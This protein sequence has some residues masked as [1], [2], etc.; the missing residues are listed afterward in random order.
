MSEPLESKV[1]ALQDVLERASVST[2]EAE[3]DFPG[4]RTFVIVT[5]PIGNFRYRASNWHTTELIRTLLRTVD[6]LHTELV[7]RLMPSESVCSDAGCSDGQLDQ[8][9]REI[10]AEK[11]VDVVDD[12]GHDARV[13][14]AEVELGWARRASFMCGDGSSR[15]I[16]AILE[17][18]TN[19]TQGFVSRKN[20]ALACVRCRS[21]VI[22][23][24]DSD[25][26]FETVTSAVL[27]LRDES[28]IALRGH[29]EHVCNPVTLHGLKVEAAHE[30][31]Q[32]IRC[33]CGD[34]IGE[35]S[36]HRPSM[37]NLLVWFDGLS[38]L[39]WASI[40][41]ATGVVTGKPADAVEDTVA[42]YDGDEQ[43][44]N[45]LADCPE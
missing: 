15:P 19:C 17:G 39:E 20:M 16:G 42:L 23:I 29:V 32:A 21:D 25:K 6:V 10:D 34:R 28:W 44:P 27:V 31:L 26:L 33:S 36:A 13:A 30:A 8:V 11:V 40:H 38:G 43:V 9:D 22:V 35:C 14:H 3:R 7:Q 41:A 1:Y 12:S 45:E 37:A 18:R 24:D 5:D 2:A 4:V